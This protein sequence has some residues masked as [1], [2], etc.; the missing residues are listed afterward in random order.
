MERPAAPQEK[1]KGKR[2]GV[3]AFF[4]IIA[5]CAV[6]GVV[7][8]NADVSVG[9]T[10]LGELMPYLI[11]IAILVCFIVFC[12]YMF[13]VTSKNAKQQK[14]RE[15]ELRA[16]GMSIHTAFNHVNGLPIAENMLCEIFSYPDRLEFK[17]GTTNIM[18]KRNK[19]TDMCIKTD[20]EIQKQ[21]VS[22]AGGAIAGAVMFGALG[23]AIG[24]RTKTKKI[25]TTT[26][27]LIIIYRGEQEELK[28]IGF[29]INL[30]PL[31]APKLVKEFHELNTTSGIQIEL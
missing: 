27:Y 3:I 23:A 5:L 25:K 22:S 6:V 9:Q 24:G 18:L 26:Q 11:V 21:A 12:I 15:D 16:R 20:T 13:S 7:M 28:Y 4:V 14:R 1:P 8:A 17:S 31:S 2:G 30:N 29:D 10:T 19:I